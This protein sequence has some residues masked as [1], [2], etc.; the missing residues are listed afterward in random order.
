MLKK[1]MFFSIIVLMVRD[2]HLKTKDSLKNNYKNQ[3]IK[4]FQKSITQL[5]IVT[6][7]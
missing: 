1:N 5:N 7:D 6:I 3:L 4:K 2:F